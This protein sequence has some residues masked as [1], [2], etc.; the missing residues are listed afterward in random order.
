MNAHVY[1]VTISGE[2]NSFTV[3]ATPEYE[4]IEDWLS[5][6]V[7]YRTHLDSVKLVHGNRRREILPLLTKIQTEQIIAEI[8]QI[9][10]ADWYEYQRD[11]AEAEHYDRLQQRLTGV[12]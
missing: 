8:D 2:N 4:P 1:T 10:C 7:I 11:Q 6:R 5:N 12:F 9:N 3:E